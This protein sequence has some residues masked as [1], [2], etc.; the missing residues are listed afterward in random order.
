MDKFTG[1]SGVLDFIC[2]I[3]KLWV[4]CIVLG[5]IDGRA[6]C[7]LHSDESFDQK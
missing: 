1:Q 3:Y 2:I 7:Q 5:H 6:S 4:R